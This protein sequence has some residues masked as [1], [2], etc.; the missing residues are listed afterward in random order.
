MHFILIVKQVAACTPWP[1]GR[2][3]TAAPCQG[4]QYGRARAVSEQKQGRQMRHLMPRPTT[5]KRKLA[6]EKETS[7]CSLSQEHGQGGK[8]G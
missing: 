4:I 3:P 5:T 7:S 1:A 6:K 2:A 8:R